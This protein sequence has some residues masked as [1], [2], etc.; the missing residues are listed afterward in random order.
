MNRIIR[1]NLNNKLS[2]NYNYSFEDE[3]LI[4]VFEVLELVC[5]KNSDLVTHEMVRC[6]DQTNVG[7]R[8]HTAD[9]G[10]SIK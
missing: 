6:S 1:S 5:S 9:R 3:N 4:T 2:K 7:Q 10:S 8:E